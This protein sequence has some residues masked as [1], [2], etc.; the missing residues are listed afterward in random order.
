MCVAA[1][2]VVRAGVSADRHLDVHIPTGVDTGRDVP[3]RHGAGIVLVDV[4]ER[5]GP[6][7]DVGVGAVPHKLSR[8]VGGRVRPYV[9]DAHG[10]R[11]VVRADGDIIAVQANDVPRDGLNGQL[12][13]RFGGQGFPEC[14]R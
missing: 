6:E 5:T 10:D 2:G 12:R 3:E 13:C 9:A 1:G 8:D 14:R 4:A 11:E 7:R